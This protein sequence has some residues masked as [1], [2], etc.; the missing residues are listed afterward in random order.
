MKIV[1]S[2]LWRS[3]ILCFKLL[4]F[5]GYHFKL[6]WYLLTQKNNVL[7]CSYGSFPTQIVAYNPTLSSELNHHVRILRYL[8]L[9]IRKIKDKHNIFPDFFWLHAVIPLLPYRISYQR[10]SYD[11]FARSYDNLKL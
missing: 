1:R 4:Y 11:F 8:R 6:S 5:D 10:V 7:L 9:C 3:N 2:L